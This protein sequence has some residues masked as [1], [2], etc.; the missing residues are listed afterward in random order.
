M[1]ISKETNNDQQERLHII[2]NED[3]YD[4][5]EYIYLLLLSRSANLFIASS[6][7]SYDAVE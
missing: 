2:M 5:I 3:Q 4:K 6:M 7:S 1:Y